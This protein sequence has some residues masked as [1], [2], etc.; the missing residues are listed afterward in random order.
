[1]RRTATTD[2]SHNRRAPF[3]TASR[4]QGATGRA[5]PHGSSS[6]RARAQR[7]GGVARARA[8]VYMRATEISSFQRRAGTAAA[9]AMT[10]KMATHMRPLMSTPPTDDG[11]SSAEAYVHSPTVSADGSDGSCSAGRWSLI[12]RSGIDM[13]MSGMDSCGIDSS[14]MES[15]GMVM[16]GISGMATCGI[17]KRSEER[18]PMTVATETKPATACTVSSNTASTAGI[19]TSTKADQMAYLDQPYLTRSANAARTLH[20]NHC[21]AAAPPSLAMARCMW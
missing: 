8:R 20:Q 19:D 3:L 12:P 7:L 13:V 11:S 21:A 14:G 2:V 6:A 5:R 17:V 16:L 4:G 1:M 18:W 15:S 9:V 10:M